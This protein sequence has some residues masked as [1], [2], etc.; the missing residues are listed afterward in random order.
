[1]PNIGQNIRTML[2]SIF[3]GLSLF[4]SSLF[5]VRTG[6]FI[7]LETML[8]KSTSMICGS[9]KYSISICVMML[10]KLRSYI[11]FITFYSMLSKIDV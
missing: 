4:C 8:G 9:A 6:K 11:I 7:H 10:S 5:P 2:V 3:Q 1:M